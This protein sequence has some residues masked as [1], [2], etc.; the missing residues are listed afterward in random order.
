MPSKTP[1]NA[2]GRAQDTRTIHNAPQAPVAAY[3]PPQATFIPCP[4]CGVLTL[5][6]RQGE[7]VS[8]ALGYAHQQK[9]D[10]CENER[11]E[12]GEV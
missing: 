11:V 7:R 3:V 8:A 5:L 12:G 9:G 6:G 10:R 2:P 1:Q 4:A